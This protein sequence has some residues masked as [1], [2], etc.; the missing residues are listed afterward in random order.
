MNMVGVH[1]TPLGD[2]MPEDGVGEG[3]SQVRHPVDVVVRVWD[4]AVGKVQA[5]RPSTRGCAAEEPLGDLLICSG[6][7]IATKHGAWGADVADDHV[8][9]LDLWPIHQGPLLQVADTRGA[10]PVHRLVGAHDK[11]VGLHHFVVDLHRRQ[12][13]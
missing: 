4:V 8:L 1:C 13:P 12:P 9:A 10:H 5:N 2:D 7:R 3:V 6:R 11:V